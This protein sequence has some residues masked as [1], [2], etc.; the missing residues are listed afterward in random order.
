MRG[1]QVFVY[2]I[3]LVTTWANSIPEELAQALKRREQLYM[4][5]KVTYR[6]QLSHKSP[7]EQVNNLYEVQIARTPRHTHVA[8]Q[9]LEAKRNRTRQGN[10]IFASSSGA[11][12]ELH[13]TDHLLYVINASVWFTQDMRV[14][15]AK[16]VASVRRYDPSA[17]YDRLDEKYP[18]VCL[19]LYD[20][21]WLSG[22]MTL[23][24]DLTRLAGVR[25]E[26]VISKPERWVLFGKKPSAGDP[27]EYLL[28]RVEMRKPDA[29][30]L[31]I[32]ALSSKTQSR[33]VY[34]IA[35]TRKVDGAEVPLII[36]HEWSPRSRTVQQR[37]TYELKA[38]E[39]LSEEE[40]PVEMPLGTEVND[41]RLG[42]G[43]SYLWSG[44]LPSE[45]ELKRLAYQQGY[46]LPPETP[47]QRYSPWLFV[48]AVVFFVT[49]AYLYWRQRRR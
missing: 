25:W 39:Q 46:L 13:L 31:S 9:P 48:P 32:E 30:P 24:L 45:E 42:E 20:V 5:R 36:Q 21:S 3:L 10:L 19:A 43:I 41:Y 14:G 34:H 2:L 27:N 29:L 28:L 16:M 33:H 23:G 4:G 38:F 15:D 18:S 35:G 17:I 11:T 7:R 12:C 1:V 6:V 40:I 37:T 44:R 26:R 47:R 22:V 8:F 49:A